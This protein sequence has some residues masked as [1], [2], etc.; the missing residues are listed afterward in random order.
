MFK[1]YFVQPGGNNQL[2]YI[3]GIPSENHQLTL[4]T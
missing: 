2:K 3:K 4:N 1:F